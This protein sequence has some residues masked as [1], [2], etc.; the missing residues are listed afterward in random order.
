MFEM[1]THLDPVWLYIT[2]DLR[3]HPSTS[4]NSPEI[5]SC[6]SKEIHHVNKQVLNVKLPQ[7]SSKETHHLLFNH[8]VFFWVDPVDNFENFEWPK[9]GIGIQQLHGFGVGIP[10]SHDRLGE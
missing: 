4:P 6:F 8:L 1:N 2:W 5:T 10:R 9:V 3:C 7:M